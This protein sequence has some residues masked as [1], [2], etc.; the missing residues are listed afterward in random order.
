MEKGEDL[1]HLS[2]ADYIAPASDD[3]MDY[4]GGFVVTTGWG[5]DELAAQFEKENDDYHSIMVKALADRLAEAFAECLHQKVRKELWGYQPDETLSN[6]DLIAEKYQGIRP[7]HPATR[8]VRTTVRKVRRC[9][10]CWMPRTAIGAEADRR[11]PR[12][13]Q[14]A[15]VACTSHIRTHAAFSAG[16]IN[17]EQVDDLAQRKGVDVDGLGKLLAPNMN[18]GAL[19]NAGARPVN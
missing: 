9:S 10:S 12:G 18:L 4:I 16:K 6:A 2:L 8:P 11:A 19:T 15:S 3:Y 17:Q 7:G 14:P 1:D 5:A 13:L